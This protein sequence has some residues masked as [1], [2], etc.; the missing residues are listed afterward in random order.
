VDS[1][2]VLE[3]LAI[4]AAV[5]L[6]QLPGKSNFGVITLATRHSHREVFAGASLGLAAATGVS[7]GLGYAAETVL[8]PYLRW[9]IVVGGVGLILLGARE[10]WRPPSEAREPSPRDPRHSEDARRVLA[11]S[12][13]LAFLLEMGDNT[14]VLAIVFVAATRNVLLVYLAATAALVT[15]T[16]VSARGANWLRRRIPEEKLR[17]V[18]GACLLLVGAVTI[19]FALWPG[20]SA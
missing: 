2:L 10:L 5:A 19:A 6:L 8:G 18:L 16:A 11:I 13:G 3:G 1:A 9:V 14:Q 20:A 7:V 15:V 12:F 17:V 4:F